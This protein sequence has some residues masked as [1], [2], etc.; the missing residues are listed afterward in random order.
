MNAA[1]RGALEGLRVLELADE[2]SAYCGKLFADMGADVVLVEPPEGSRQRA[3]QPFHKGVAGPDRGLP[4]LYANTNKR[5]ITLNLQHADGSALF[6]RLALK[7]DIIIEARPPGAMTALGLDYAR[8]SRHNPGLV[9]TSITGFGQTGPHRDY[10]SNDLVA[11]AMGGAMYVT[12][13]ESDPPVCMAN[14]Q[15]ILMAGTTAAASSLIA[16][17]HARKSGQGQHVDISLQETTLSVAHISGVGK[18]LDDDIIPKRFGT[19]L[20]ASVPSGTY[21]CRDGLVYLMVNRP[22][23]W[24]SLAAWIHEETGNEEVLD[25]M[26]EGPSSKRIEYRE[27]LDIYIGDMTEKHSVEHIYHEG[28]RRHIAF[29]PVNRIETAVKDPQLAARGFFQHLDHP[30]L[31]PLRYPGAPF[32]HART[33]WRLDASAPSLG[34]HNR[35]VFVDELGLTRT[36]LARLS[37]EAVI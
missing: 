27:L 18:W 21:T 17:R 14:D 2:T 35:E 23:H 12:G 9:M 26:F 37:R 10:K 28:Q 22:A 31:G 36:D 1:P 6:A 25:P 29:T 34:A 3:R 8:L 11:G 7:A 4:F 20:F 32:R 19:A 13:F 30:A 15:N 16:L 33:P 24:Q 5:G